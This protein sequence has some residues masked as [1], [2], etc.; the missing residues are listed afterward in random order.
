MYQD[1][2]IRK[3]FFLKKKMGLRQLDFHMQKNEVGTLH[4]TIYKNGLE[5]D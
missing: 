1:H 4:H 5:M 3:R 2:L